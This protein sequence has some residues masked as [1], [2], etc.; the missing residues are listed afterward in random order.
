MRYSELEVEIG[1]LVA[2]APE[3]GVRA[4]GAD[5]V[6]RLARADR[7]DDADEDELTEDAWAALTGACAN[8]LTIG[9][10]ELRRALTT[11]DEGILADG[12]LD[13]EVVAVI[14]ALEHWQG[15][16]E[17]DGRDQIRELALRAIE[18]VDHEVSA[19]LDD[20]LAAPEVA[21]EYA[22]LRRFLA[23]RAER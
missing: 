19:A 9:A 20:F 1:R 2:A 21:A 12:D 7:L 18:D 15:Y 23:P 17:G 5:T 8:V 14:S 4:F 11:I 10:G 16:L 6:T 13:T 22:R 3:Q